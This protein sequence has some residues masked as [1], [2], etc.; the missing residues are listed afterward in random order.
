MF[1]FIFS[2]LSL[3]LPLLL[4]SWQDGSWIPFVIP[5]GGS[6]VCVSPCVCVCVCGDDRGGTQILTHA[7]QVFYHWAT[8]PAPKNKHCFIFLVLGIEPQVL[9]VPSQVLSH[10]LSSLAPEEKVGIIYFTLQIPVCLPHTPWWPKDLQNWSFTDGCELWG[11]FWELNLD[12]FQK[13]QVFLTTGL[14]ITLAPEEKV[15]D[16]GATSIF[17]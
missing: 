13:R 3:S 15:F 11:G 4:P 12:P 17:C 6:Y 1:L 2:P 16:I 9:Y 10:W 14:S 5:V 7:E 8:N